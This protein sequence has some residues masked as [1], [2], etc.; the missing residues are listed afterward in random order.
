MKISVHTASIL[1]GRH[2]FNNLMNNWQSGCLACSW[3][4]SYSMDPPTQRV[5]LST[6][7]AE[8]ALCLVAIY[9][10]FHE[11]KSIICYQC[12]RQR[13]SFVSAVRGHL[14]QAT[15]RQD[16]EK[17]AVASCLSITKGAGLAELHQIGPTRSPMGTVS[18]SVK[19]IP[20]CSCRISLPSFKF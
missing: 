16:L 14:A 18:H 9:S 8:P 10:L 13:P 19:C 4:A 1:R 7:S 11:T 2:T 5:D 20:I 3:V 17:P 6:S 15:A 12:S